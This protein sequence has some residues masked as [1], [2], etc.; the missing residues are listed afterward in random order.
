MR[1]QLSIYRVTA[2]EETYEYT[3]EVDS[4]EEPQIQIAVH[5]EDKDKEMVRDG[6]QVAV[7]RMEGV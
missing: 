6:L 5:G 2:T 4:D 3:P 1:V 7:Y